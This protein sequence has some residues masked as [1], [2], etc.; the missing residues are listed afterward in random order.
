[1][2]GLPNALTIMNQLCH[3]IR[4]VS[5]LSPLIGIGIVLLCLSHPKIPPLFQDLLFGVLFTFI[6]YFCFELSQGR[7]WGFRYGHGILQNLILL[8]VL[9]FYSL[10]GKDIDF[11]QRL[12]MPLLLYSFLIVY[13]LKLGEMHFE[14]HPYQKAD[15]QIRDMK[16]PYVILSPR[17]AWYS[18]DLI[19]NTP[20]L[21]ESPLRLNA[22]KLSEAQTEALIRSGKAIRLDPKFYESCGIPLLGRPK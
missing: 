7:G 4:L 12:W 3:L 20:D 22:D 8:S 16:I 6:F 2:I 21:Q 5:W 10:P 17:D 15:R 11:I 18:N 13:P 9:G 1:M 14:L 19:R